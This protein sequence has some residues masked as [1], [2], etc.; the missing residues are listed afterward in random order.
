MTWVPIVIQPKYLNLAPNTQKSPWCTPNRTTLPTTCHIWN[1]YMTTPLLRLHGRHKNISFACVPQINL[2][3]MGVICCML[4][5][6][7]TLEVVNLIGHVVVDIYWIL[8]QRA[9]LVLRSTTYGIACC[10]LQV[11]CGR[12]FVISTYSCISNMDMIT[13]V[14]FLLEARHKHAA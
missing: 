3:A 4:A 7:Y 14:Y 11:S 9:I 13:V 5:A 6:W 8:I 12:F 10:Q 2:A 1:Q